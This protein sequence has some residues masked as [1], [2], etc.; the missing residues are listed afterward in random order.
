MS[1]TNPQMVEQGFAPG[2]PVAVGVAVTAGG[3]LVGVG[4]RPP[5]GEGIG[6]LLGAPG[7]LVG[8]PPATV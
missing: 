3:V 4:D 1:L 8:P 6:V 2:L 7:V 5:V